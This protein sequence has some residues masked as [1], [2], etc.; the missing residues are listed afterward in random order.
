MKF[1][2]EQIAQII[3]EEI[4]SVLSEDD[5]MD[6]EEEIK[7]ALGFAAL[8]LEE[9]F[10][11]IY[12]DDTPGN[13]APPA[14]MRAEYEEELKDTLKEML[15]DEAIKMVKDDDGDDAFALN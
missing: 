6:L 1:T 4:S 3:K 14:D 2:L 10:D 5:H 15:E 13:P 12:G 11:E 9:L 8:T 7:E